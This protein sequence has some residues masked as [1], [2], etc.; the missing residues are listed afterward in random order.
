MIIIIIISFFKSLCNTNIYF[1]ITEMYIFPLI[2]SKVTKFCLK[3]D[4]Q[5]VINLHI[6]SNVS[7]LRFKRLSKSHPKVENP[8]SH[9]AEF[10]HRKQVTRYL[11]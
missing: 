3:F 6:D 1:V 5:Y 8:C 2:D 9:V 10:G 7:N 4:F 11:W